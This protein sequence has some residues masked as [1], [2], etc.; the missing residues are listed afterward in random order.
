M[1]FNLRVGPGPG[2]EQVP[3]ERVC[4]TGRGPLSQG[5]G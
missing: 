3:W 5:W 4:P 1:D 2:K